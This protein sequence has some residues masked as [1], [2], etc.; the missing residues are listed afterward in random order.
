M[1]GYGSLGVPDSARRVWRVCH[2]DLVGPFIRYEME[3][4]AKKI[5]EIGLGS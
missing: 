2:D 3:E 5:H 1:G 4:R